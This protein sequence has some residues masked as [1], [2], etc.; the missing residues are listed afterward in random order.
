MININSSN[1]VYT[2]FRF[3]KEDK[4]YGINFFD[5]QQITHLDFFELTQGLTELIKEKMI[6][7]RIIN[8]IQYFYLTSTSMDK[9]VK[10]KYILKKTDVYIQFL[11]QLDKHIYE[12]KNVK[13]Y[14]SELCITSNYLSTRVKAAS[15]KTPHQLITEFVIKEIENKLLLSRLT[16]KQISVLFNFP[17]PAFLGSFF[18]IY[19]GFSPLEY[20]RN[21]MKDN[22]TTQGKLP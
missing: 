10:E 19:T 15:G 4:K 22:I 14:A 5:L 12:H 20:R 9:Y 11:K 7:F 2:I 16:I 1:I 17:N 21:F 18:K 8:E 3:I 6:D 13:Y